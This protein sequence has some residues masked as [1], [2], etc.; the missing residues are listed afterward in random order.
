MMASV[1][2]PMAEMAKAIKAA[3]V[4]AFDTAY[5]DLTRMHQFKDKSD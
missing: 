1:K 3:D 2:E 5:G 4:A